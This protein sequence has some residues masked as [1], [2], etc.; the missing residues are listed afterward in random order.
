M[1]DLVISGATIVSPRGRRRANVYVEGES[2][3]AIS[4]E[5]HAARQTV[6][7][8]GLHILPGMIDGHVHDARRAGP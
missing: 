6:D 1:F 7:A 3:A 8:T 5:H 4:D 2:I